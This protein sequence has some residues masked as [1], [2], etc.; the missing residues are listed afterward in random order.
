MPHDHDQ[1]INGAGRPTTKQD[2]PFNYWGFFV[3]FWWAIPIAIAT[4]SISPP[5]TKV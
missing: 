5:K 1:L 2:L 3:T 4:A